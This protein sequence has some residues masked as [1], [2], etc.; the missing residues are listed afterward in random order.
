INP[1]VTQQVALDNSLLAPEKRLK[2]ERCNARIE[3]SK[4]QR[5]ETYQVTLEALK[6]SPCYW[7][8]TCN[9]FGIPSKRSEIHM[10]TTLSWIRRNVELILKY[11]ALIPDGM[12]NQEIKDSKAYKTYYNFATGKVPPKKARKFKKLTFPKHT[13]IPASPKESIMK[14]K[15]VKS[16]VKKSTTAPTEGVVIRDT[17]VKRS[18]DTSEGTG[19]KPGVPDVSIADSSE[20]TH[21]EEYEYNLD[22][23]VPIDEETDDENEE[24]DDEEY[25]KLYKDVNVRSKLQ[26]MKK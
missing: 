21:D 12:I 8:S 1:V 18:S 20:K 24:F 7:K 13:T 22:D 15:L 16:L 14:S 19:V 4:L 3:F 25:D 10:H 26:N 17:P 23:Y 11:G 2:I 5:E 6:I 9:N